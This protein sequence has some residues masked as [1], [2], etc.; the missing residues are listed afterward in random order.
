LML[1]A[2]ML[3]LLIPTA[4]LADLEAYLIKDGSTVYYY[5]KGPL[6]Q[7][8]VNDVTG[9]DNALYLDFKSKFE[10]N[11]FYAF[12]DGTEGYKKY[13][14]I[15]EAFIAAADPAQFVINDFLASSAATD[16]SDLPS[17]IKE[18]YEESNVVKYR[19]KNSGGSGGDDNNGGDSELS[20]KTVYSMDNTHIRVEFS[21]V[22]SASDIDKSNFV[23]TPALAITAVEKDPQNSKVVIITTAVQTPGTKYQLSFKGNKAGNE[24]EGLAAGVVRPDPPNYLTD[25]EK[26]TII[27][28]G[29][30]YEYSTDKGTTW[31]DY[32]PNSPP[33]GLAGEVWIRKKANGSTPAGIPQIL[34]LGSGNYGNL[35]L[36]VDYKTESAGALSTITSLEITVHNSVYKVIVNGERLDYKGDDVFFKTSTTAI[37]KGDTLIIELFDSKGSKLQTKNIIANFN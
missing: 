20:V 9:S 23:F 26:G 27:G 17:T 31:K 29:A 19:D 32:D 24:T 2:L 4:A 28:V 33:E 8:F 18:A 11:G 5:E 7:S 12:Y 16:V 15:E 35:I 14:A 1:M 30:G 36:K 10:A 25:K 21:K 34:D 6:E 13:S 3:I 37:N 22:L